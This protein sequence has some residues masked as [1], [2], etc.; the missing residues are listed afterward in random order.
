M[1]IVNCRVTLQKSRKVA[2]FISSVQCCVV[3]WVTVAKYFCLF[4]LQINKRNKRTGNFFS[5][6]PVACSKSST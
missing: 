5:D 4:I 2:Q 1:V 6:S 3:Y